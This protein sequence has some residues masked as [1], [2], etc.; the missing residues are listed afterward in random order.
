MP[1]PQLKIPESFSFSW[2]N[3]LEKSLVI[4]LTACEH[5]PHDSETWMHTPHDCA[6]A[7]MHSLP[8]VQ[9]KKR[10][11]SFLAEMAK[12]YFHEFTN[13]NQLWNTVTLRKAPTGD[14]TFFKKKKKKK[15]QL[16]SNTEQYLDW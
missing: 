6:L 2:K 3:T 12:L 16:N 8:S 14:F 4:Q 5:H 11:V 15:L 10:Q 13:L 9:K 1:R 7:L